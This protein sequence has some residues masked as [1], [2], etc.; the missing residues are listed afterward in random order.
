M[1][2][3][4]EQFDLDF[5]GADPEQVL[6]KRWAENAARERAFWTVE[7]R[8]LAWMQRTT[9]DES[10]MKWWNDQPKYRQ[11]Y[12]LS[13]LERAEAEARMLKRSKTDFAV[14]EACIVEAGEIIMRQDESLTQ[15]FLDIIREDFTAGRPCSIDLSRVDGGQR[16]RSERCLKE[17]VRLAGI[18]ETCLGMERGAA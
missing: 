5:D 2:V 9:P 18:P 1:K 12:W 8:C 4:A 6:R 14:F 11:R 16:W 13:L 17:A 7:R 15:R 10:D 3:E